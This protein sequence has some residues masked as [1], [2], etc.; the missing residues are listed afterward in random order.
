MATILLAGAATLAMAACATGVRKAVVTLPPAYEAP[1]GTQ[2]L[3]SPVLDRWW[4]IFGDDQLNQLEEQALKAS[5]DAKTQAAR[6]LEAVATRKSAILQTYPTG[7]LTGGASRQPTSSFGATPPG[8]LFP[9]GGVTEDDHLDFKV[10]WEFDFLGALA[11][12]RKAARYDFTATRFNVE[13]A[14]A[15]LVAN[16]ADSYF[17]ARGFAIQIDD[18]TDQV[19]IETHLLQTATVKSERGLG[20][21]SD[22]DRLAGDLAQ[23]KSNLDSLQAQEHAAQRLLLILVGRG[24]EPVEHLPL[25]ADVPD[26]PPL[27]SAVPGELLSRRPDVR[28]ADAQMRAAIIRTK[29]DKEEVF[30]NIT[31][32]PALGIAHQVMPGVGVAQSALSTFGLAFFPQ[33]QT[34]NTNYWSVGANIDQPVLDIPRLLQDA[35]AQGARAEQAVVAYEQSVQNA[36]GDAENA[37]VELSSDERRIKILED[38][39][40]RARRAY[41]DERIRYR[42]GLDDVTSVLSAEQT[43]R[44]DRSD[45]TAERVQALRR[46]VQTY[47]ALGGGWDSQP[48]KTAARSP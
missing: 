14:R 38:G 4:T 28:E 8:D 11:D 21:R 35:K 16:V 29:L 26:P 39:E 32:V 3:A 23:A 47:K 41:D 43:W 27:P 18:A 37:L 42:A 9:V 33:Q 36:Y 31:I 20:P 13:A 44:T 25:A 45:L 24:P 6:L 19:N 17:Q 2:T 5:P 30:P 22:A 10:S 12:A 1:A 34:T 7:D 48:I 40:A 15:S 46:A